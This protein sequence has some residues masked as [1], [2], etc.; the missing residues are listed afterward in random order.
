[1]TAIKHDIWLFTE[2]IFSQENV[3]HDTDGGL[4]REK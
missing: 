2:I 1:M 4:K 3:S